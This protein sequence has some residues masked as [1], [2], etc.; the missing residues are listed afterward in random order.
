MSQI[1]LVTS[2]NYTGKTTATANIGAGLARSGKKVLMI[3]M[4]T[5][6]GK[7]RLDQILVVNR[8]YVN[9]CYSSDLWYR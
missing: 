9:L 8:K 2:P 3:D 4:D 7:T 6:Y 1:I 5:E